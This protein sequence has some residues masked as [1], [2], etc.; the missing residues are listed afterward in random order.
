MSDEGEP[1]RK[2]KKRKKVE[3]TK[4]ASLDAEHNSSELQ[5]EDDTNDTDQETGVQLSTEPN[6]VPSPNNVSSKLRRHSRRKS[7]GNKGL[8]KNMYPHTVITAVLEELGDDMID[9]PPRI[10]GGNNAAAEI[11]VQ[12]PVS[13]Q[14]DKVYVE[15]KNGFA[16]TPRAKLF[17]SLNNVEEGLGNKTYSKSVTT[18]LELAIFIQK[19]CRP[20]YTLGH[21]ML[22]GMAVLHLIL[23]S[24]NLSVWK[25]LNLCRDIGAIVGWILIAVFPAE[26]MLHLH[27]HQMIKY[28]H[29]SI[30]TPSRY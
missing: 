3:K 13:L 30:Q 9:E 6:I 14:P 18:P 17:N 25:N 23:G 1:S 22:G 28:Q 20:I 15:R 8:N 11:I 5:Y 26:D 21:G 29:T 12:T 24:N 27:L 19:C 16:L 10:D 4:K 2:Q 7:S